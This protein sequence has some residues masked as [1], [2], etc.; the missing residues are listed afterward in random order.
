MSLEPYYSDDSVTIY[1]GDC[2]RLAALWCDPR[3]SVLVT[4]PPYGIAYESGQFGTLPRSIAN[5]QD[6]ST[7]DEALFL[8]GGGGRPALVFGSW[9]APRPEHTRALLIWDTKGALGMGAL[10]I[11]WKPAHQ[12]IYVLGR[13][14][15]GHRGTDVLSY[16]PVQSMAANGRVHPNEK[17]VDLL[18]ALIAK[19]PPGVIVDPF[20]GSGSTLRAAKNLGRKAVGIE[21]EER[22]CEIAARR[23]GQEVLAL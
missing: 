1:H 22:Y 20:M 11:P 5:D 16:A 18:Q 12:E 9:R 8:W 13:G 4:D 10:D 15:T 6:T 21:L 19:C 17:P 7:R 14:F 23:M 2:L 3:P